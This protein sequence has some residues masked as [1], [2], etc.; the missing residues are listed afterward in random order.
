MPQLNKSP[1]VQ[2]L[3]EDIRQLI[4]SPNEWEDNV[5]SSNVIPNEVI[6]YLNV[7]RLAMKYRIVG[8]LDGTLVVA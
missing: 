6:P 3:G 8:D 5:A 4:L 1:L 7:L 2:W